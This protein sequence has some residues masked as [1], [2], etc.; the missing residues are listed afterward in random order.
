MADNSLGSLS[1]GIGMDTSGLLGGIS[2]AKSM[3]GGFGGIAA[4]TLIGVGIAAVGAGAAAV[5][6]AG[7]W[8]SSMTMLETGAGESA[9]NIGMV[10][11]GLLNIADDTGTATSQLASSMFLVESA[12]YRGA[13]GLEVERIAAE[14]AKVGHADLTATTDILTTSL[15]DYSLAASQSVPVMNSLIE[16]VKDG[17]M[18]M[19]D[20]NA[21]LTSVLPVASALHVPIADVEGALSVMAA[22]GDKGAAAGT[23]LSM[24]LK[25]LANPASTASKEMAAMGLNSIQLAEEMQT[26]LPGALAMIQDAVAKHFTPGSVEYNR[27]VSAILGGSKSGMAGLELMGKSLALFGT[28]VKDIAST[29]QSGS[30]DVQGWSLV[31]QDFNQKMDQAREMVETLGI[32]VGTELL[33][34]AGQLFDKVTPL[35][36]NFSDWIDKGNNLHDLLQTI[37]DVIQDDMIDPA[38]KLYNAVEPIITDFITWNEKTGFLK[39][40][41]QDIGGFINTVADDIANNIMPPVRSLISNLENWLTQSNFVHDAL[42]RLATLSGQYQRYLERSSDGCLVSLGSWLQATRS[43]G[44]SPVR[45]Q[46]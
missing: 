44:C 30:S 40:T 43:C 35:I 39:N 5:K 1:V 22:A 28:N 42:G 41:L 27:A 20:L 26:S 36:Q 19:N 46:Q 23:H 33:P 8:Q 11:D 7:T 14:G 29:M 18:T 31:Q 9:K 2:E 34:V 17:K 38:V 15:H 25:M 24:M 13:A 45:L 4:A 3:L 37:G 32:K 10:S 6:A 16:T 12:G 21:S